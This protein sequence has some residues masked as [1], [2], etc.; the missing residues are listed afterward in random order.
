MRFLKDGD[1]QTAISRCHEAIGRYGPNRNLFLVKARAHLE[2]EEYAF[3]REALLQLLSLDPEHPAAWA[4]LGEVCYRLGDTPRVDYCR[5]RLGQ[6]FPGLT[7]SPDQTESEITGANPPIDSGNALSEVSNIVPLEEVSSHPAES[8]ADGRAVLQS[9]VE[10]PEETGVFAEVYAPERPP[11]PNDE[12]EPDVFETAT[13]A[14]I[15]LNQGKLEKA[16][17]IYSKLYRA[18]PSNGEY[19]K[20]VETIQEKMSQK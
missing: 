13:F 16:L 20:K 19:Q 10:M 14:E 2:L 1:Q 12:D 5:I 18:N 9:L 8:G 6:I 11:L 17:E 3:A 7:D 15:C 4:M